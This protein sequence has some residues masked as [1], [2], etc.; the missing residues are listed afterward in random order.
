MF[1][2]SLLV[3]TLI[4][5]A[6]IASD[7]CIELSEINPAPHE[8]DINGDGNVDNNDEFIELHNCGTSPV[9]LNGYVLDDAI[10]SGSDSYTIIDD[11][12]LDPSEYLA[13]FRTQTN[14]ALNNTNESVNL[15]SADQTVLDS[16]EYSTSTYD[17]SYN[18]VSKWNIWVEDS[19]NPNKSY[20]QIDNISI[21]SLKENSLSVITAL[22]TDDNF[23][24]PQYFILQDETGILRIRKGDISLNLESTYSFMG[25]MV[26]RS[27][28]DEFQVQGYRLSETI[29]NLPE[30]PIGQLSESLENYK[31]CTQGIVSEV[32]ESYSI[33]SDI[34]DSSSLI[35]IRYPQIDQYLNS[36]LKI[37]G[38]LTY[39][40]SKPY[41]DITN[42]P[43]VISTSPN[44][45]AG[46]NNTGIP[47]IQIPIIVAFT[48]VLKYMLS[49][50]KLTNLKYLFYGGAT[51]R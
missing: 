31:V 22:V 40:Y 46:L 6:Q 30:Y 33:L 18:L 16:Y 13:F 11:I 48:T 42:E 39:N 44:T 7:T 23:I 12:S 45:S 29:V 50:K 17:Q 43:Q 26:D 27:G 37:C 47:L 4:F 38:I 32:E 10:G 35:R 9:N 51:Y 14:I 34:T 24:D 20:R 5:Q 1:M 21:G 8:I 25:T 2:L 36:T 41:I 19:P 15:I 3:S 49:L 28:I